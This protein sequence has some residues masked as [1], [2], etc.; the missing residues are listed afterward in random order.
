MSIFTQLPEQVYPADGAIFTGLDRPPGFSLD[1][2]KA[3]AWAAQLAYESDPGKLTA[4]L[5]R[6]GM[7]HSDRL[8]GR[9]ASFLPIASTKG[10]IARTDV[11]TIIAFGGTDPVRIADWVTDFTFF[12]T[13]EGIHRGFENG[14][15][16][17]WEQLT[18]L[19][20]PRLNATGRLYVAG[21]S[22]GAALAVIA[23]ER[24]VRENRV[25]ADQMA[26][27]YTFGMP[28]VGDRDF[29]ARYEALL[30][31]KT[32]R[33]AYGDDIVPTVPPHDHPFG[34]NHVGRCLRCRYNQRFDGSDLVNQPTEDPGSLPLL[35]A[36]VLRLLRQPPR[37]DTP[38]H[39]GDPLA[40]TVIGALP[41]V[42]RDH[43]PDSYLRGLGALP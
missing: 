18:A 23:A 31:T 13:A 38:V 4:I 6:W 19:V 7:T 8:L 33:L 34:F 20:P 25:P 41:P 16:A 35:P 9:L 28:R 5:E 14:V 39:P 37:P 2:A 36:T 27:I 24:L 26:G 15:E 3:M 11:A 30:G 29:A 12:Q 40:A 17:I 1:T 10:Y 21:H 43:I 32:F 22:L 42:V